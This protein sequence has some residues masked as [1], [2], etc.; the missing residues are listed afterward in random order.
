MTDEIMTDEK[1]VQKHLLMFNAM[2]EHDRVLRKLSSFIDEVAGE[3]T[4]EGKKEAEEKPSLA[5]FLDRGED[6]I[7]AMSITLTEQIGRLKEV[8]F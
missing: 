3:G 6:R 4:D 1:S 2:N 7:K 8:L 5:Q